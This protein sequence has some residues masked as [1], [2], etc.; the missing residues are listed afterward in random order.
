MPLQADP[1]S[2][3]RLPLKV[4]LQ[5]QDGSLPE[6]IAPRATYG[7]IPCVPKRFFARHIKGRAM[8]GCGQGGRSLFGATITVDDWFLRF[9]SKI[10]SRL[11]WNFRNFATFRKTGCMGD[12]RQNLVGQDFRNGDFTHRNPFRIDWTCARSRRCRQ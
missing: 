9:Q 3:G 12:L 8:A 6:E 1:R 5:R 2:V 11:N 4:L 7:A 10:E